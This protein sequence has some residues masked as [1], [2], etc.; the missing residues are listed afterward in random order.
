M[1][2]EKIKNLFIGTSYENENYF[3]DSI[4][5][6]NNINKALLSNFILQK[7]NLISYNNNINIQ[8][9]D[10]KSL[11]DKIDINEIEKN[12]KKEVENF[13]NIIDLIENKIKKLKERN[14][15]QIKLIKIIILEYKFAL[16][17]NNLNCQLALNTKNIL[18]FNQ[19]DN[20]DLI[21]IF[22]YNILKSYPIEHYIKEST[23]IPKFQKILKLK[24]NERIT[25]IIY[26]EKMNKYIIYSDEN[27]YLINPKTYVIEDQIKTNKE[28]LALNLMKDKETIFISFKSSIKKLKIINNK[29]II[30]DY[31]NY[32]SID[33][34]GKIIDYKNDIAWMNES[35]IFINKGKEELLVFQEND[36]DY[37]EKKQTIELKNI[38]EY[39]DNDE[40]IL[41]Y[42]FIFRL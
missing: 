17:S 25:S 22:E 42:I 14:E 40:D 3:I 9:Y 5:L 35:S 23:S 33:D 4:D 6:N 19:I 2:E 13:Y 29:L 31:L 41:L 7:D 8:D 15:E 30:E 21:N 12:F 27:I 36:E 34:I 24:F 20:N 26:Y 16:N 10:Y 11:I 28:L 32:I 39:N 37:L 18:K 38:L 1:A